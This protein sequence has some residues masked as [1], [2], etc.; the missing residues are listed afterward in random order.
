LFLL[1]NLMRQGR[2]MAEIK[3][4]EEP[5]AADEDRF[6]EINPVTGAARSDGKEH[7][8]LAAAIVLFCVSIF[9]IILACGYYVRSKKVFYASPGLMPVIIAS[10]IFLLALSLMLQSLKGSSIKERF[11]Q[12]IDA[13]PRGIKSRRFLNTAAALCMFWVYIFLL[14]RFLP[15]WIASLI[16]LCAVFVYLKASTLIKCIIIA[17]CSIGGIVLLFQVAFRVPLP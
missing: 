16:L 10:G 5:E 14:L 15:F 9:S 13:I 8:D 6:A 3:D 7:L 1:K 2:I 12:V 4:I 11:G 17:G